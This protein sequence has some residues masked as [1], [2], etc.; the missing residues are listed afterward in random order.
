MTKFDPIEQRGHLQSSYGMR[1]LLAWDLD[2]DRA[3]EL[4]GTHGGWLVLEAIECIIV[5]FD[6]PAIW[7]L[8]KAIRWLDAERDADANVFYNTAQCK[9]LLSGIHDEESLRQS[10]ALHDI[11]HLEEGWDDVE[12][13]LGLPLWLE[14]KEYA[15]AC[16][17]F[18]GTP[19]V[20]KPANVHEIKDGG[21]LAYVI[22]LHRLGREYTKE[23]VD[24]AVD[25]YLRQAV[26]DLLQRGQYPSVARWMKLCFWNGIETREAAWQA[27]LRCYDFMPGVERPKV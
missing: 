19:G 27:L 4:L 21:T 9:W 16:D 26:P 24:I 1:R 12:V 17:I 3:R 18:E 14:A 25:R 13:K 2:E 20:S 6:Q 22:C 23:E 10:T 7:L 11:D 5:G 15:R 8:E